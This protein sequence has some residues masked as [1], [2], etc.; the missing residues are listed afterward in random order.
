MR[1]TFSVEFKLK[2]VKMVTDDYITQKSV[3][4]ELD[5]NIKCLRDG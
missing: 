4:E 3:C 2:A 1:R 5:I